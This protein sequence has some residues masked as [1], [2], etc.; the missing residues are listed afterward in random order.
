[1]PT[2]QESHLWTGGHGGDWGHLGGE[3]RGGSV[4]TGVGDGTGGE[5]DGGGTGLG[6]NG[7]GDLGSGE[8]GG[9]GGG[10]VGGDDGR[11]RASTCSSIMFV[12]AVF[13][14]IVRRSARPLDGL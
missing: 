9:N 6:G 3:V 10:R 4:G 11:P 5:G 8:G 12:L 13:A 2:H 7:A 1:M 14:N